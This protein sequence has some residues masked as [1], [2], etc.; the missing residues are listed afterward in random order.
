MGKVDE[1]FSLVSDPRTLYLTN[2]LKDTT[3]RVDYTIQRRQGL[4]YILGDVGLGKTSILRML[5]WKY[6][7]DKKNYLTTLI[8]TPHF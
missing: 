5:H 7:D 6:E 8:P 1:G 3:K 2:A 4:T